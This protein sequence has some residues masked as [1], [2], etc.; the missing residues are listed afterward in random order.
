MHSCPFVSVVTVPTRFHEIAADATL[1]TN[2]AQQKTAAAML[3]RTGERRGGDFIRETERCKQ[4]SLAK[5][6]AFVNLIFTSEFKQLRK[7][8]R[9]RADAASR[10]SVFARQQDRVVSEIQA[11]FL[12]RKIGER[13]R[14]GIDDIAVAVV[15]G[16]DA[17]VLV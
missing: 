9:V 13:D 2:A 8:G 10:R 16:E 14:L 11:D 12:K 5:R 17:G 7:K 1:L 3:P 15:T 4:L 6:E